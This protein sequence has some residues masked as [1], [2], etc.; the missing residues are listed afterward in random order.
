VRKKHKL[1]EGE[2]IYISL[3]TCAAIVLKK[4]SVGKDK[5]KKEHQPTKRFLPESGFERFVSLS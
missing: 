3:L 4:V 5:I 1:K 2:G